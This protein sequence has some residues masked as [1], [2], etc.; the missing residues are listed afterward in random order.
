M[1][2]R[3]LEMSSHNLQVELNFGQDSPVD[4]INLN[5]LTSPRQL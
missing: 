3:K 1:Q 5:D 2:V 4:S